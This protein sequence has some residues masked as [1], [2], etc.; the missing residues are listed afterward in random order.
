MQF[1]VIKVIDA[2]VNDSCMQNCP[3][4]SFIITSFIDYLK[5]I[6]QHNVSII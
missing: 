6:L 5:I 3:K 1:Y 4:L 2:N